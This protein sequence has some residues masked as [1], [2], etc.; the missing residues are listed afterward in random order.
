MKIN[1]CTSIFRVSQSGSTST[2]VGRLVVL[3]LCLQADDPASRKPSRQAQ[4]ARQAMASMLPA[5]EADY[6]LRASASRTSSNQGEH[7][8]RHL[9]EASFIL[10]R[11][12]TASKFH[13]N[14]VGKTY[15]FVGTS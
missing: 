8:I 9:P 1:S 15:G 3:C 4:S 2:Q 7:L 10:L 11:L 14:F 6:Y 5:L 13:R 12:L